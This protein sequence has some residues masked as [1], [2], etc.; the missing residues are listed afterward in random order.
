MLIGERIVGRIQIGNGVKESKES[1]KN[2]NNNN[3]IHNH[4]NNQCN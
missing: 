3:N 4:N 2:N 1:N